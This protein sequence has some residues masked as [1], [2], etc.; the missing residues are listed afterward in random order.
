MNIVTMLLEGST[1]GD[2]L[3]V[4]HVAIGHIECCRM[5]VACNVNIKGQMS[6]KVNVFCTVRIE[7]LDPY[8]YHYGEK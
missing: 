1:T 4:P 6:T 3:H 2:P 5:S 8:Y 7:S